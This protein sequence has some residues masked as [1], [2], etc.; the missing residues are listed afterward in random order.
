MCVQD[1][2]YLAC[3]MVACEMMYLRC[4]CECTCIAYIIA[5]NFN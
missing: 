2:H 5:M 4:T 1:T 3:K